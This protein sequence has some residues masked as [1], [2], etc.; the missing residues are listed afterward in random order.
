MKS[1]LRD[2][3]GGE[4]RYGGDV[5]YPR[6]F[7]SGPF[8]TECRTFSKAEAYIDIVS[9]VR[10]S[11]APAKKLMGNKMIIWGKRQMPASI[12]FLA[13][14]WGWSK[15]RVE[16]FLVLLVK[17]KLISLDKTQGQT[18]ITLLIE[19]QRQQQG[20]QK[21]NNQEFTNLYPIGNSEELPDSDKDNFNDT[22]SDTV[23]TQTRTKQQE[24]SNKN[25]K[26]NNKIEIPYGHSLPEFI[27]TYDEWVLYRKEKKKPLTEI[28]I[29]KQNEMLAK[30]PVSIAIAMLEQSMTNGYEGIFKLKIQNNGQ[31]AASKT[32]EYAFSSY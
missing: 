18:V 2:G 10:Y 12:R 19:K 20:Q 9:Q 6:S 15:D 26:K 11:E 32:K 31:S 27:R 5:R 3:I 17:E 25:V 22:P 1:Y 8:W 4:T 23:R 21:G 14:R 24:S 29:K 16:N 7:F 30:E 28:T 13:K